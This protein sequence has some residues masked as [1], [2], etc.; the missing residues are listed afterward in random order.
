MTT[1]P[2]NDKTIMLARSFSEDIG[3]QGHASSL[4]V[5]H[6]TN[7]LKQIF[8]IHVITIYQLEKLLMVPN[9]IIL[10]S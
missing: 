5:G 9:L 3:D 7:S 2:C 4:D 10:I 8:E 1:D 6:H